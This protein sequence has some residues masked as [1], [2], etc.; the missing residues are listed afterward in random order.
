METV[1]IKWRIVENER[2]HVKVYGVVAD[3]EDKK[4]AEKILFYNIFVFIKCALDYN[5]RLKPLEHYPN[6]EKITAY[7][8]F[9]FNSKSD[10]NGFIEA[11]KRES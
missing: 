7:F 9:S 4:N 6:M 10:V 1:Y 3:T 11:V 5:G 2:H 8:E